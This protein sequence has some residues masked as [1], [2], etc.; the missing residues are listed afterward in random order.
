MKPM[1]RG[2]TG[3]PKI[4]MRPELELVLCLAS[5]KGAGNEDR[6]RELIGVG[7]NWNEVVACA[8]QHNLLPILCKNF[9]AI[10]GNWV[11][12]DQRE[13]LIEIQRRLGRS[14]M[15]L[16]GEMR[17]LYGVF[18]NGQVPA[19]PF[20]G[21]A[22][23][24]LAYRNFTLRTYTDLDFVVPQRYIPQALSLLEAAGYRAQFDPLE[25]QAGEHGQAPGQYAF[26]SRSNGGLVGAPNEPTPRYFS[27]FLAT[28]RNESPLE[29]P[30]NGPPT[31][32]AVFIPEQIL[33]ILV[34]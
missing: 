16:L 31:L 34:H 24:W 19:I 7:A 9:H 26:V 3:E 20:K 6:I 11:S 8:G 2:V 32:P 30:A 4:K 21:P 17:R 33:E 13:T 12:R 27:R 14:S 15:L 29:P 25:A 28:C 5:A 23:A 10:D 18:E 22:L 1:P